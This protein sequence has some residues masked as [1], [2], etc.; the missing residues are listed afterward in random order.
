MLAACSGRMRGKAWNTCQFRL[1]RM[2]CQRVHRPGSETVG[3]VSAGQA[4]PG[5]PLVSKTL[6]RYQ[7]ECELRTQSEEG[8]QGVCA[9]P[10]R[11]DYGKEG[12]INLFGSAL[13]LL[14][15]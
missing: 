8:D 4:L 15:S 13:F 5:G 7:R 14:F 3:R 2:H 12:P 10:L 6:L 11:R 9:V 1:Q